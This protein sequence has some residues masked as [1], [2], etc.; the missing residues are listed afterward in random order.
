M[1]KKENKV[2]I[3]IKLEESMV[4]EL[5]DFIEITTHENRS[6]IIRALLGIGL[7]DLR[8]AKKYGVLKMAVSLKQSNIFAK[9]KN[10]ILKDK[11][12]IKGN[13]LIVDIEENDSID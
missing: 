5:D 4:K 6:Q 11:A 10:A 7:D 13:Q 2:K 1:A 9:I 3:S 8:T 12:V